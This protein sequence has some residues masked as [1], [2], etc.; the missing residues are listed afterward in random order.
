MIPVLFIL[1]V[2]LSGCTQISEGELVYETVEITEIIYERWS[3]KLVCNSSIIA[4]NLQDEYIDS[5]VNKDGHISNVFGIELVV[6]EIVKLVWRES[7][8]SLLGETA[9]Y[10]RLTGISKT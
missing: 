8:H 9:L 5:H 4:N 2:M 6:G 7:K 1:L 10:Y 3:E